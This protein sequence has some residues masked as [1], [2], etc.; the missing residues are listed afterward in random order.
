[1]KKQLR[2]V[3]WYVFSKIRCSGYLAKNLDFIAIMNINF[4]AIS[5]IE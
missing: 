1:M 4:K 3:Q 5:I 2:S